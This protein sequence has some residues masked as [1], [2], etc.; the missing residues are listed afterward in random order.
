MRVLV[1]GGAGFI[2]SVLVWHLN[3][4]GLRDILVCDTFGTGDKWRNLRDLQFTD[5]VKPENLKALL[6][7]KN[8]AFDAIFH[9]G[10]CSAT[11]ET[12]MDFL[13][14]NN[15]RFSRMLWE[16]CAHLGSPFIYASSAATYGDGSNGWLDDQAKI[17]T[18]APLNKY[19]WSKQV[20]DL[21][22]LDQRRAPKRWAGLKFFNV[23]GPQE[24]HKGSMASVVYHNYRQVQAEGQVKLFQ[25]HR[26]GIGDGE[27]KRDFIYVKDVVKMADFFRTTAAPNGLYNIATGEAR[28]FKDFAGAMFAALGRT[29]V[30]EYIPTPESIR[31]KYQY[32]T[33]GDIGKIR[34]A[35]YREPVTRMEEA[36]AD[37]V[38][39]YLVKDDPWL[40]V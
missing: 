3:R 17:R 16:Y 4:I 21:W 39:E 26:P 10:A 37:Y 1:T 2:G 38:R 7:E 23:Y 30:I 5:M 13:W 33:C 24:Y 9:M 12:D 31:D 19:G 25:S 22:A 14:E 18:L 32:Y 27:Q 11:T 29:P 34:A 28:T 8:R 40:K 15:V 20:F 36:V 35:G 6:G